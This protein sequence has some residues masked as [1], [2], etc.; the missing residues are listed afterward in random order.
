MCGICGII[1]ISG[2]PVQESQIR[3]M[4]QAM[5]HRGPDDEGVYIRANE[6]SADSL[7]PSVGLGHRRLSI[8]DLSPA[9][10]QPMSNEDKSVWIVFNGEIY[11]Y[12]ELRKELLSKGHKFKSNTDTEVIIYLYKEYGEECVKKLRGMFAFAIWD[13]KKQIL[14]LVRDR[15]GKKPLLYYYKDNLFCFSSEFSSLLSS[16]LIDR[17]TNLKALHYYLTF[18]YIP[19][20]MT[21]YK[22]V[23]KLSPAHIL[24]FK[25]GSN[26]NGSNARINVKK[27]WS[28]DYT[29]KINISEED[30]ADEVLRL[31]KEAVKIR[32]YSDVP[33]GAFLSGG[34][35]SSAVVGL[36]SQLTDEKVKTFSIGFDEGI[37]NELEFAKK[38]ALAFNTE[39]YEFIVRPEVL[40]I[41][42]LLVERCGEPYGDSSIIP[43]YYVS[44]KTKQH[45]TVALNGDGGDELFAGYERYQA[46]LLSEIFQKVPAA[47]Q[48]ALIKIIANLIP[49]SLDRKNRL[50]GLRRFIDG[51]ALPVSRRYLRWIGIFSEEMRNDM[52][53]DEFLREI[54]NSNPLEIIAETLNCS[55]GDLNLLDRLLLTDTNTYLPNDLL[56]KVDIA[57]MAN[58]LEC[59][60]PFLDHHL[61]EFVA[62]L[63][64]GLKLKGF[65]KKYI[66][67]KAVKNIIPRGN[68]HRRKMGFAVPVGI[69][70]RGGLKGFL[71]DILLSRD[72]LKR[73]FLKPDKIK[74]MV[75]QHISNR[76]DWGY[77]LWTLL[78][79]ELWNR[80]FNN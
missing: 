53:T 69:W 18:G 75:S 51:A 13:E 49:D 23:F 3:Q 66:L 38:A 73:G 9:G 42:P 72:S 56:I 1:N 26:P 17:Q 37:Y 32:L 43:T 39:H 64:P 76:K 46:M 28:L 5:I 31:L 61:M 74:D 35:D 58:S 48:S 36:M 67:K 15:A 79:L 45:V 33:L 24:I 68:M 40:E 27:Y 63:P 59:R 19:A 7:L 12:I 78:M 50:K 55:N 30:A 41:L 65:N 60:S 34:I 70:F 47:R 44:W 2:K 71:Q 77:H 10:H 16:G 25:A 80:R 22:N 20:P 54:S 62:S 14:M 57:S 29:K 52:Y 6:S 21:I 8:I 11:N 4:C